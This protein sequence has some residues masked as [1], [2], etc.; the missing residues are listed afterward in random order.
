MAEQNKSFSSVWE[1]REETVYMA[2][3]AWIFYAQT[4]LTPAEII[5]SPAAGAQSLLRLHSVSLE[6]LRQAAITYFRRAYGL[7]RVSPTTVAL[8]PKLV[9]K[10]RVSANQTL[11]VLEFGFRIVFDAPTVLHGKWGGR[12]GK[13]VPAG[14]SIFVS[15]LYLFAHVPDCVDNHQLL[16]RFGWL[17][18]QLRIIAAVR[19]VT[20]TRRIADSQ[21]V[22]LS[23]AMRLLRIQRLPRLQQCLLGQSGRGVGQVTTSGQR[24]ATMIR[25]NIA[26]DCPVS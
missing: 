3:P 16:R 10:A 14:S 21:D 7:E 24:T 13:R 12:V 2:L 20:P 19:S 23:T 5:V 8:N 15:H 17:Q 4:S 26:F 1:Q 22:A 6:E 25:Q 9:Y 11:R 18:R